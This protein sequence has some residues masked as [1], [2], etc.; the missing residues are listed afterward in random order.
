MMRWILGIVINAVIVF[1][2]A[3]YLP[4]VH[5]DS[6]STAFWIAILLAVINILIWP[7]KWLLSLVTLGLFGLIINIALFWGL[8]FFVNGFTIDGFVP[9][10]LGGLI[11]TV[12]SSIAR[13]IL[14]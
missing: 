10:V 6:W 11:L 8:S 7:I 5:V 1:L 2:I 13:G 9:A 14:K 12:A 4:G 3:N